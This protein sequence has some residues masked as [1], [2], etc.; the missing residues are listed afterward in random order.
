M[1]A[2][3]AGILGTGHGGQI[4]LSLVTEQLV[5]EDLPGEGSLRDLGA[6]RLKDLGQ[7]EHLFLSLERGQRSPGERQQHPRRA[8]LPASAHGLQRSKAD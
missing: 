6:H 1:A 3:R 4:L 8:E 7:P 5:R 2:I